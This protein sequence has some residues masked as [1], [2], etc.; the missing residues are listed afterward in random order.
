MNWKIIFQL[1]VFGLIM[2]VA[3]VSL[4]PQ[5]IEPAFWIAI[6]LFSAYVIAK[7]CTGK[8]FLHGFLVSLV[9]CVWITAVHVIFYQS[10]AAHH[11]DIVKMSQGMPMA[12]HPRL[13]M[14]CVAP[15]FGIGSGLVLGFFAFIAS[16]LVKTRV[17]IH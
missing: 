12:N 1:S 13:L 2:A 4:I 9:N 3:T 8:Y 11:P 7:T 16:K 14:L 10:Y 6:F 5:I 15:V 17:S